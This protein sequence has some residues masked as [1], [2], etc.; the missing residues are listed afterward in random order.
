MITLNPFKLIVDQEVIA[1]LV[2][3]I[4][5]SNVKNVPKYHYSNHNRAGDQSQKKT[6]MK[7]LDSS[8]V[9]YRRKSASDI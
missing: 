1:Y 3:T 5:Q 7:L 8:S 2:S 9:H 6:T 4:T